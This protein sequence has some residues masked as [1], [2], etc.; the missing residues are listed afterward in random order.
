MKDFKKEYVDMLLKFAALY[1]ETWD[2]DYDLVS[3]LNHDNYKEAIQ[4]LRELGAY[5]GRNTYIEQNEIKKLDL[6][7][8]LG[9]SLRP[10]NS[11]DLPF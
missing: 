11:H 7:K 1:E 3:D 8:I 6:L 2:Q 10:S 9:D 5:E 4:S